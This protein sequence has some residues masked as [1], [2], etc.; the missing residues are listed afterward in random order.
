MTKIETPIAAL[1]EQV[2]ELS[3]VLSC[4]VTAREGELLHRPAVT[5]VRRMVRRNLPETD[6]AIG[7]PA[8]QR[9]VDLLH[10]GLMYGHALG[11][12]TNREQRRKV[13]RPPRVL[14]LADGVASILWTVARCGYALA[15]LAYD[16]DGVMPD[17]LAARHEMAWLLET[18]LDGL[19]DAEAEPLTALLR[20]VTASV[21]EQELPA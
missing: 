6:A 19:D 5:E 3:F 10:E 9:T 15:S 11:V 20:E 7:R 14:G 1:A 12:T 16:R 13:G 21:R 18:A 4:V 8:L 2:A 17:P